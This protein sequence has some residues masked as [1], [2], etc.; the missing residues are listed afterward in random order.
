LGNSAGVSP[1]WRQ[2]LL[3]FPPESGEVPVPQGS[4]APEGTPPAPHQ[5]EGACDAGR[6]RETDEG[7]PRSL[8]APARAVDTGLF[9]FVASSEREQNGFHRRVDGVRPRSPPAR[10]KASKDLPTLF[11]FLPTD[12][13]RGEPT[14]PVVV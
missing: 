12:R 11:D 3:E 9:G 10:A 4:T 1:S 5:S 8:K 7:Q 13:A 14:P 2:G 6:K